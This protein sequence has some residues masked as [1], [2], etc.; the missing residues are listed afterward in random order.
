MYLDTDP[1]WLR[2]I[3]PDRGDGIP[4]VYADVQTRI[5]GWYRTACV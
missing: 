2:A 5:W 3:Q 4:R 1:A